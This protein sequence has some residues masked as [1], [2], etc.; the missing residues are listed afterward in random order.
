MNVNVFQCMVLI[1]VFP[2]K[3]LFL[4]NNYNSTK[5]ALPV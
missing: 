1:N 3:L 4:N 2:L 5:D